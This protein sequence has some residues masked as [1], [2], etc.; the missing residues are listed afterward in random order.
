MTD[1][2][3]NISELAAAFVFAMLLLALQWQ[4][5]K[6]SSEPAFAPHVAQ[7]IRPDVLDQNTASPA[8]IPPRGWWQII[9]RT[10]FQIGNNE[11]M[12]QAAAVT[13]YGLL[14]IFPAVTAMVSLYGL[15]ADPQVIADHL[16]ALA[17]V[18]PGGGMDIIS[19][20][21]KHLVQSP[22]GK[23]GVGALIGLATAI[24]SA[25][26]GSKAFFSALNAV[27]GEKERRSFIMLTAQSLAF[28]VGAMIFIL[29]ALLVVIGIPVILSFVGL[30]QDTNQFLV[31]ARWPLILVVTGFFLACLYRFGPS[32]AKPKWR[33]VTWGSVLAA[34][35]WLGLS[36]GFSWY[37]EHFGNYNKTYGSLGAVIGFMTWIWLSA[38]VM[39]IGAQLNAEMEVQRRR[40]GI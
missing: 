40:S 13:F 24:W 26:Q 31:L 14:G 5:N 10:V 37:V 38:T 33:W 27:Y 4:R 32:R 11:L 29:L 28:T 20:Q 3:Q 22:P 6:T 34:L 9:K 19:D 8:D 15:L 1:R 25:N 30:K 39:L 18:I 36:A 35:A 23:L 21:V 7:A 17:G 2:R 12:S 16:N